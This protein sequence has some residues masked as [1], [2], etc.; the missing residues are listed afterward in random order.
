MFLRPLLCSCGSPGDKGIDKGGT[1]GKEGKDGNT[2]K[3]QHKGG[4]PGDKGTAQGG[5]GK[6]GKDCNIGKGKSGKNTPDSSTSPATTPGHPSGVWQPTTWDNAPPWQSSDSWQPTPAHDDSWDQWPAPMSDST[7][8]TVPEPIP[9]G[10]SADSAASSALAAAESA[11]ISEQTASAHAVSAQTAADEAAEYLSETSTVLGD[12]KTAIK[13]FGKCNMCKKWYFVHKDLCIFPGCPRNPMT[14]QLDNI[15]HQIRTMHD[16]VTAQEALINRLLHSTGTSSSSTESHAQSHVQQITAL[17]NII[18]QMVQHSAGPPST[19]TLQLWQGHMPVARPKAVS[20]VPPTTAANRVLE[21][22]VA[23]SIP[24]IMPVRPKAMPRVAMPMTLSNI[25]VGPALS[26]QGS[27]E[28]LTVP[29][30]DPDADGGPEPDAEH[31]D[32]D[33]EEC[34]DDEMEDDEDQVSACEGGS[35]SKPAPKRKKSIGK[36]PVVKKRRPFTDQA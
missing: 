31:P 36:K 20:S 32:G 35:E 1:G 5:S 25:T 34:E 26:V 3:G 28:S 33:A 22:A 19:C 23:T 18:A 21:Q 24:T 16:Q 6:E 9:A 7:V 30:P 17:T 29:R 2:G 11:H 12:I 4:S 15:S 27:T 14:S 8:P 10:H 13:Q